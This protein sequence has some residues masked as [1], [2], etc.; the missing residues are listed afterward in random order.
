MMDEGGYFDI[1]DDTSRLVLQTTLMQVLLVYIM[2]HSHQH[3]MQREE[4]WVLVQKIQ[5]VPFI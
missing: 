3:S 2:E 4:M 5:F 1:Q